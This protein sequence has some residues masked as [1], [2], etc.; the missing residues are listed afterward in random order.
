MILVDSGST[1]SFLDE[2]VTREL[3]IS[4]VEAPAIVVIVARVLSMGSTDSKISIK[5]GSGLTHT[6]S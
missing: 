2:K 1:N 4:M 3:K 6:K 5:F